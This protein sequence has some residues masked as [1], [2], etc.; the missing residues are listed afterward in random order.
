VAKALSAL[1][2]PLTGGRE[3]GTTGEDLAARY[4]ED[5]GFAVVN[6][7]FRCRSGEIDIVARSPEGAFVF[8]EVKA[9]RSA[10]HG[11]GFEAV[12]FGKRRRLI[13]A[14]RLYVASRGLSEAAL[15]FD[16]VSVLWRDGRPEIRHDPGAF[17]SSGD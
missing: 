2:R 7:N 16:V 12:T 3:T 11:E 4:L 10:S 13:R 9:R 1:L 17:S 6:R 14:A 8:V 15:R 5:H